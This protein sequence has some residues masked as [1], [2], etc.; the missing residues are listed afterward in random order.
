MGLSFWLVPPADQTALLQSIMPRRPAGSLAASSYPEF[1]PHITLATV[2][3]GS[4][5]PGD[6]LTKLAENR[7]SVRANF[8]SLDTSDHYFRSVLV[9]VEP[10]T[11]LLALHEEIT[12]ALS[13]LS[14]S[15]PMF[16]HMSLS[17]IADED[18]NTGERIRAEQMIRVTGIVFEDEDHQTMLLR[19]GEVRLSGF[20]G[21][22]I[23]L[24]DCEG[25]VETWAIHSKQLLGSR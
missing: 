6:L 15:A 22:E 10:T 3:S 12:R 23:W 17:Y 21:A 4:E 16:P 9:S 8:R 1:L 19:C 5:I 11:D 18:A 25:P 2:P 24:V 14:P 13:H 7:R 20:D